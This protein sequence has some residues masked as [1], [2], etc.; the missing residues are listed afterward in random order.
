MIGLIK[1]ATG[2]LSLSIFNT[3]TIIL[4]LSLAGAAAALRAD[5]GNDNRAP[6]VP[7]AIQTP[8][9]TNKV[10]FHVYAVGVQIY[11][12]DSTTFA[13]GL[14]APEAMLFDSEGNLVG[15]HFAYGSLPSGAPIPAWQTESGSLAVGMKVGSASGGTGNIP[16]LL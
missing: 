2:P 10:C 3:K 4:A 12:N 11:T 15:I 6:D 13:W 9:D 5:P 14:K 16:W 8:G 1:Q 7:T